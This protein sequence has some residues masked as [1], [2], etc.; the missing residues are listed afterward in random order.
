MYDKT[1][2]PLFIKYGLIYDENIEISKNDFIKRKI[3]T[4]DRVISSL[5]NFSESVYVEIKEGMAYILIGESSN[6]DFKLFAIH[7][8][9]EI[10]RNM[11]FNII[12]MT[13]QTSYNLIIPA[14]YNLK[15]EFLN[16]P[17]VYNRILPTI[18]IPE[19]MAYYYTIKSPNY[20]FKG[21]SHNIYELTFVDNG[22]LD[23]TID[24]EEFN[25]NTYDMIVYEKN[26]FHTQ[27]VKNDNSC[28]YLTVM[29]DMECE[30]DSLI[31]NKVFHCEKELYKAIRVFAKNISLTIPYSQ[32]LILSNFHEVI[33]RL[34]QYD[35]VE[36][37]DIKPTL[38]SHQHFQDELLGKIIVY[39][40]DMICEPITIEELCDKFSLSRSSLQTLFKNNL[41]TTPKKYINNLKLEKSKRLIKE[42]KFT[43]SEIAFTLGFSSIHYFSRAF[44]QHFEISPS[45]Y[46][47]KVYKE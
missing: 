39:I 3:V 45:D 34:F 33:I 18:N 14:N 32:N 37:E 5:Y 19:I 17:Y 1:S 43:I 13:E 21:E 10:K 46:A 27:E 23:T 6:G 20:K 12:S 41:G 44:T 29:F 7:R 8:N 42:N 15:L 36:H 31:C 11:Y 28:S 22:N 38:E 30:D 16:P 2:S 24:G 35:Y 47:Q 4:S 25:L 26:K 40:D 9:L